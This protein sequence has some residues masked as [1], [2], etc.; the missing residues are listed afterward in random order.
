MK[1]CTMMGH[2]WVTE[3]EHWLGDGQSARYQ[4]DMVCQVCE[5]RASYRLTP[6]EAQS[7]AGERE[8]ERTQ[9]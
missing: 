4:V 7:R 3:A 8:W 9:R 2:R 6:Q 1:V 5:R